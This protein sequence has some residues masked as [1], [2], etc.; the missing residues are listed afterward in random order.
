LSSSALETPAPN[1]T[2]HVLVYWIPTLLWLAVL[3]AFSS[4]TFSAEHTGRILW[5]LVRLLYG[6]ISLL[7]FEH[8]HFLVR[9]SAHFF[10]YG[11]LSGFA[12]FTWRATLP[13]V[14]RWSAR[15]C[16]LALLL[17]LLAGSM[18]EFHQTFVAS[19]TP[20]PWDV[21][22]DMAGALFFQALI[23]LTLSRRKTP[24]ALKDKGTGQ[25]EAVEV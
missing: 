6:N 2:R 13:E 9:K 11:L 14:R 23:A 16:T 25:E 5:K 15:W 7:A 4:D 17:T 18:D 3:A 1:S 21:M 12:F 24:K 8:L 22:I 19:R 20:A 10:S